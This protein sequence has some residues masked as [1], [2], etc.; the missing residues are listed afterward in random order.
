MISFI[1]IFMVCYLYFDNLS[2]Q[3]AA[4]IPVGLPACACSRASFHRAS[5]HASHTHTFTKFFQSFD[6]VN[7]SAISSRYIRCVHHDYAGICE[8]HTMVQ[9][10]VCI[11][12]T[13]LCKVSFGENAPPHTHTH[14]FRY[15]ANKTKRNENQKKK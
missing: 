2:L 1:S 9:T 5:H 11:N 14:T 4:R 6:K 3:V 10:Y 8:Q 7:T 12:N 13:H 15:M